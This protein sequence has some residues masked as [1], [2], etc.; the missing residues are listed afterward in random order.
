LDSYDFYVGMLTIHDVQYVVAPADSSPYAGRP[1][2]I[3]GVVTAA[4]GEFSDYFF[5]IQNHYGLAPDFKGVKVYDRTGTVSVQRG[6][7]VTVSGDVWEYYFDTEIAMFFPEAITVH[8]HGNNVPA[9]YPVTTASVR[10][11]EK[12][13]GVLVTAT[14]AV[15]KSAADE[16]GEWLISNGTAADTCKVGD[17]GTYSYVP[18]VNDNVIVTG[19]VDYTYSE[20]KIEPR[21]DADICSP[22]KADVTDGKTTPQRLALMVRPNPMLNG[23]QVRFALP[24]SGNVD[25][26]VYDVKGRLVKTLASGRRDAG[27]YTMEWNGTSG[28]GGRV[29]SGIYFL[30]LET[31]AGSVATKVVVSR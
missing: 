30:R 26:K 21:N 10:T 4:S 7:S 31:Q 17:A 2:N 6:D 5:Y 22:G 29:T 15:V 12:Y 9:P 25:L 11:S 18:V 13:E 23:G 20:Y 28:Q 8:S 24:V 14:S 19:V 16:F 27:D 1:V 3:S